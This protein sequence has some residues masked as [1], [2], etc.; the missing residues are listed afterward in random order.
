M[1][2]ALAERYLDRPLRSALDVGCGEG[3]WGVELRRLRPRL[4]YLGID[5]SAYAVRRFGAR[6]HLVTGTFADLP[7]L[8]PHEPLDLVLC[9]DVLHYLDDAELDAGLPAL[10]AATGGLAYLEVLS[11][12]EEIV[13]DL[14]GLRRRPAA[15]WRGRFAEV[16]LVACGSNCYLAAAL[17]DRASALELAAPDSS[18]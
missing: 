5:P 11:A 6:R 15:W 10:G 9:V 17:A 14:A 13:G 7:A 3:S 8:V 18:R 2:V 4:R 16:G 1:V 12:E